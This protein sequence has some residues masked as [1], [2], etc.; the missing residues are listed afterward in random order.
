MSDMVDFEDLAQLDG[1]DL[2]AVF[3]QVDDHDVLDALA[4]TTL[5]VRRQFLTKLPPASAA[6]LEAEI[7]E[8]GPVGFLDRPG[9]PAQPGR[10]PL[11]PQPRGPGRLRRPGRPDGRLTSTDRSMNDGRR[12]DES[13][14]SIDH[15][16][17]IDRDATARSAVAR[18]QGG[19][20]PMPGT[21]RL[22]LLAIAWAWLALRLARSPSPRERRR[23]AA[24]PGPEPRSTLASEEPAGLAF[25]RPRRRL[26]AGHRRDRRGPGRLRRRQPGLEAVPALERLRPDPG[27]RPIGALDQALGLPAP[28]RRPRPDRGDRPARPPLDPRRGHRPARTR[29][30]GPSSRAPAQSRAR[31][32]SRLALGRLR[33]ADRR[34]RMTARALPREPLALLLLALPALGSPPPDEAEAVH[35]RRG[36]AQRHGQARPGARGASDGDRRGE[37]ARQAA[38]RPAGRSSR[39]TSRGS[40][41]SP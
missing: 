35:L 26:V 37:P 10:S 4:G 16:G 9:R 20:T 41:A 24:I 36:P 33:P 28:G 3:G 15:L 1:G 17:S 29:P 34:R 39:A 19:S 31:S 21:R 2:K 23:T 30:P 18:S 14:S 11:P 25:V 12:R 27:G 38:R 6:K 13:P 7:D 5:H 8:H 22:R 40:R 32:P